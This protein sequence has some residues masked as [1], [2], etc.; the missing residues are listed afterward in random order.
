MAVIKI[1]GE[2]AEWSQNS[3]AAIC[4]QIEKAP[5]NETIKIH[6]H[7]DGGNVVE[8]NMIYN[9]IKKSTN[10]IDVYVDGLAASMAA[11][12]AL[13]A[14]NIYMAENAFMM[15]HAPRTR[16][17]GTSKEL[18]QTVKVL[19]SMETQFKKSLSARTGKTIEEVA[20]WMVGDNWF[21]AQEAEEAGLIDG[22]TDPIAEGLNVETADSTVEAVY[23]R[24]TAHFEA[25]N[26]NETPINNTNNNQTQNKMNKEEIIKR[27]GL[28]TVTAQS[29][30][31]EIYTAIDAK[32]KGES[33]AKEK[34]QKELASAKGEQITAMLEPFSAKLTA[35]EQKH[36]K[37]IGEKMGIESLAV[38]L[39]QLGTKTSFT[40]A[41]ATAHAGTAPQGCK[42]WDDYQKNDP[43]ALERMRTES[44]DQFNAL[45]KAEYGKDAPKGY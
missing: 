25:H 2:L 5:K 11:I 26:T 23:A 34:A 16:S 35:D 10:Q 44:P 41:I 8:G 1:Y 18:A 29:S 31:E 45:F 9:A 42:T 14:D 38:M 17:V 39:K 12:L 30:E 36:Y 19:T 37:A 20:V 7:S 15:I 43:R 22:I 6:I 3:A 33:D 24:F 21:S 40:G 13:A 28:T 27:Y 4:S 32:F